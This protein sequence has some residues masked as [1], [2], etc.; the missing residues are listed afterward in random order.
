MNCD[1][2]IGVVPERGVSVEVLASLLHLLD[3]PALLIDDAGRMLARNGAAQGLGEPGSDVLA[4]FEARCRQGWSDWMAADPG[5]RPPGPAFAGGP[6][7]TARIEVF[8]KRGGGRVALVVAEAVTG[9]DAIVNLRHDLAGPV[10]AILGSA[11]WLLMRGF[12]LPREVRDCLGQILENCGRI[13]EILAR[14]GPASRAGGS[15]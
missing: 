15:R 2:K 14:S 7:G 9:E 13:S 4:L 12:D 6:G 1:G 8:E 10:T 11:E 5:K 3:R